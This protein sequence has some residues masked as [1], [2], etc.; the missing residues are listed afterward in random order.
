MTAGD[1]LEVYQHDDAKWDCVVSVFFLDTARNIIDYIDTIY[2][3][4][5]PNGVW[6]NFGPLLYHFADSHEHQS[7]ELPY[8]EALRLVESIGFRIEKHEVD[9][10]TGYT[11]NIRS[12]LQYQYR[13]AY[14]ECVKLIKNQ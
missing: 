14:F 7:I 12:M 1:F 8:A 5:K 6:I 2:R 13:C 11:T 9:I 10:A 3:I 4:L